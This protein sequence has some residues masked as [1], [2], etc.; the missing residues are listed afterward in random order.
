MEAWKIR[1]RCFICHALFY[2]CP[3]FVIPNVSDG[4]MFS[5]A[6]KQTEMVVKEELKL[7]SLMQI[8]SSQF[9][10]TISQK[11]CPYFYWVYLTLILVLS[12][13][14]Y[15]VI[16]NITD[17]LKFYYGYLLPNGSI[18][19]TSYLSWRNKHLTCCGEKASNWVLPEGKRIL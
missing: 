15:F 18:R 11:V 13:F 17:N 6:C 19:E 2:E 4:V 9:W 3:N 10:L 8:C 1:K 12:S 5:C 16:A 14:R 7:L